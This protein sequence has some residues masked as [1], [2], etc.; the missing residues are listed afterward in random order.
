MLD[1]VK[2]LFG[3]G[4]DAKESVTPEDVKAAVK[5]TK[6]IDLSEGGYVS[7]EKFKDA[8][9]KRDEFKAKLAELD[10]KEGDEAL[11]SQIATLTKD[12]DTME[13][14]AKDAEDKV[15]SVSEKAMAAEQRLLVAQK[16][17][18]LSSK[19]QRLLAE[20]AA[21]LVTDEF[22]FAAALDKA[23]ADDDDYAAPNAEEDDGA[24]SRSVRF[25]DEPKGGGSKGND[26]MAAIDEA[27]PDPKAAASE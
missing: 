2:M 16:A 11:K 21:K 22:D 1:I 6:L 25:G 10:G 26:I 9:A 13:R 17:G 5:G 18:H 24:K 20:D 15:D 3:E 14:R 23:M 7:V 8:E 19:L 12:L 27:M 4:D